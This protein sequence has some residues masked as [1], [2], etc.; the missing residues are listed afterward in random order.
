MSDP[1]AAPL[2]QPEN[3]T[4]PSG[5]AAAVP[6]KSTA[7]LDA[8]SAALLKAAPDTTDATQI[9]LSNGLLPDG[10]HP[11]TPGI[12]PLYSAPAPQEAPT[13]A[14]KAVAGTIV[15]AV[16]TGLAASATVLPAPYDG[17]VQGA[18]GIL[19]IVAAFFGIYLPANKPK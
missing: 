10:S 19:T 11:A 17:Y 1:N 7:E 8:T 4:L 18:V 2:V 6:A 14:T 13:K 9:P 15:V 12:A 3:P 16:G 5:L